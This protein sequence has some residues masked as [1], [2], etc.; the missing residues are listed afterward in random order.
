MRISAGLAGAE[1]RAYALINCL[2]CLV[3]SLGYSHPFFP[4]AHDNGESCACR[5]SWLTAD[6]GHAHVSLHKQ[7]E[8]LK[9]KGQPCLKLDCMP[10]QVLDQHLLVRLMTFLQACMQA[11]CHSSCPAVCCMQ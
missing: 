7:G 3:A 9:V 11:T 6:S 2:R 10:G 4:C 1:P 5:P 8:H